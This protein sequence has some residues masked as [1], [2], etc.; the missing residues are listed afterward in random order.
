MGDHSGRYWSVFRPKSARGSMSGGP[1]SLW[2]FILNQQ[3][4]DL[5]EYLELLCEN[6]EKNEKSP[7]SNQLVS[8]IL[9]QRVEQSVRF[10]FF[11]PVVGRHGYY[12][13]LTE[14]NKMIVSRG[15]TPLHFAVHCGAAKCLTLLLQN[16]ADS[17]AQDENN[18][19]AYR[20]ACEKKDQ[21]L[22][23]VFRSHRDFQHSQRRRLRKL[24]SLVITLKAEQERAVEELN[25]IKE[26]RD[27]FKAKMT[28]VATRARIVLRWKMIV[29]QLKIN[30]ANQEKNN[31][32]KEMKAVARQ[33]EI[34]EQEKRVWFQE[35]K[36]LNEQN[37]A[38]RVKAA[39]MARDYD[40]GYQE[41][42][43]PRRDQ[44]RQSDRDREARDRD[45][46]SNIRSL[47]PVAASSASASAPSQYAATPFVRRPADLHDSSD[48]EGDRK[49][50]MPDS[51]AAAPAPAAAAISPDREKE[52]LEEIADLESALE[53]AQDLLKE[54][55]KKSAEAESLR[56]QVARLENELAAARK[57]NRPAPAPAT[58]PEDVRLQVQPDK[59]PEGCCIV[60]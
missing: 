52:L 2:D 27:S 35:K 9:D 25:E 57:A 51:P 24:H 39:T 49:I 30:R 4:E 12:H 60:S 8:R 14:N 11:N 48:D 37:A 40:D 53:A 46:L 6:E 13:V 3:V 41:P 44:N 59:K 5:A 33:L 10:K 7:E 19:T 36:M 55:K 45:T 29:A 18:F 17:T 28:A 34:A 20:I 21:E 26:K 54:E 56:R 16:C 22:L 1:V 38:L 32:I 42:P 47:A 23:N 15:T 50:Q 58:A 43:P 31:A